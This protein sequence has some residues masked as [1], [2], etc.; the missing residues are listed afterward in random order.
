MAPFVTVI[1]AT[2][3]GGERLIRAIES[4][5]NQTYKNFELLI[6]NDGS[7]DPSTIEVLD[8][9]KSHPKIKILNNQYNKGLAFSLNLCIDNAKGDYLMRMDDDDYCSKYRIKRLLEFLI[10]NPK[11]SFVG[12]YANLIGESYESKLSLPLNPKRID[13]F[14]ARGFIHASIMIRKSAIRVVSLYTVSDATNRLEDY[15]LFCKLYEKEIIGRNI[16]EYL[17]DITE[18]INW[19]NRRTISFRFREFKLRYYW[20]NLLRLPLSQ[21]PLV[22]KPLILAFVPVRIYNYI[23]SIKG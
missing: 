20:F 7:T 6:C 9:Y 13:V 11:I 8:G 18:G 21:L 16:P 2:Y 5:L 17:Y 4:I 12:S 3:N 10:K 22:F 19:N 14:N 1:M 15:D 23:R